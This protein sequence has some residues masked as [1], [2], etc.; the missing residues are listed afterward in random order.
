MKVLSLT[1]PYATLIKKGV[2]TIET[3]SWKSNY[4][5]KLYTHASSTRI[6]REYKANQ[7]LMSLVDIE[8]LSY[9]NIICCCEL[10]DCVLMTDSFIEAIRIYIGNIRTWKICMDSKEHCCFGSANSCQ[11]SPWNMES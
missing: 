5:G 9:G 10:T 11:R 2:K 3:R 7:E 6:P 4:R 1:E 8:E